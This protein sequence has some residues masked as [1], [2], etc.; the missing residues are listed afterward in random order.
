MRRS[1]NGRMRNGR[2]WRCS[3]WSPDRRWSGI[4]GQFYAL[5]FLTSVLKVDG[6]TGNLLVAWSLALGTGGFILFGWLS[7]KIGRKPII[8]GGCMHGGADLFPGIP[9]HGR[10]RQSGA[11]SR[12]ARRCA[13]WW[14]RIR[15]IAPSSSTRRACRSSPAAATSRRARCPGRRCCMRRRM[16]RRARRL[17]CVSATRQSIRRLPALPRT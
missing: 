15:R 5:F 6:F 9:V 7:D 12:A 3:A 10:Y 1:S 16:R 14:W 13:S 8:L 11:G 4:R 2:S 17:P